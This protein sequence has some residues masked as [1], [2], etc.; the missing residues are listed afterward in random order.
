MAASG[1]EV[2]KAIEDPRVACVLLD[3]GIA[4]PD[5]I[6]LLAA[7]LQ[8]RAALRVIAVATRA[9]QE[10]VLETLRRGACDYLAKPIHDEELCLAVRRAL[11]AH[12]ALARW[13]SARARLARLAAA[14]KSSN[15]PRAPAPIARRSRCAS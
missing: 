12:D 7:L 8:Q 1:A 15:E 13:E 11:A 6:G 2:L 4:Q 10:L 14:G 5:A 9:D 3:V